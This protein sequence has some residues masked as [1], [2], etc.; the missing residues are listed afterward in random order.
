[1]RVTRTFRTMSSLLLLAALAVPALSGVP[2][3]QVKETTEKILEVVKDPAL[4]GDDKAGE[5]KRLIRV[6]ADERFDWQEMARRSLGRHWRSLTDEE[7]EDFVALFSEL[8]GHSYLAKI[9]GYTGEG[10]RYEDEKVDDKYGVVETTI[11][12]SKGV[13][14]PVLYRL[15]NKGAE[16]GALWLVYDVSI[17]GV[18][19]V[20]NYRTQFKAILSKSSH[21][22][23]VEKLKAKLPKD[24]ECKTDDESSASADSQ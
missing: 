1:M 21:D 6:A 13:D 19:L 20:N 18:S 4:K 14:I 24:E 8:I 22:E 7:K 2:T 5:R 10:V 16:G 15:K 12:T 17:E 23:L 9:Q 11:V 3:E